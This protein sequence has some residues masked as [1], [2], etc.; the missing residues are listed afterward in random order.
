MKIINLLCLF[1]IS[2]NV[3]GQN[4]LK[5]KIDIFEKEISRLVSNNQ[6]PSVSFAIV[7]DQKLIYSNAIGFADISKKIPATDTT[8]YSIASLTKP[9]ASAIILKLTEQGIIKLDDKMKD[10]WL[11]YESYYSSF[12]QKWSKETPQY[13]PY[14]QN[15][16]YNRNDITIRHHLSHTSE[17]IPGTAYNYNGF[18]YGGLSIIADNVSKKNFITLVQEEIINKLNMDHSCIDF[19]HSKNKSFG[20][21]LSTPYE[22]NNGLLYASSYPQPHTLSAAAGFLSCVKDI[23][24]FD[25]A[26]DKNR[27]ISASSKKEAMKPYVLR[28][29]SISPYGLG[30]FITKVKNKTIVYHYGLQE[31]YSGIY[32]KIPSKNI[33][34]LMLSN[35][36][37]LTKSYHPNLSM[38]I[39]N[40]NPYINAFLK[41]FL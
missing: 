40:T 22:E 34:L 8:L 24:K 26:M 27:I 9:I 36:S 1:I 41:L 12:L 31:S 28:D 5:R 15:Y 3:A 13:L 10:H 39:I 18:L 37:L 11:D 30:W 16:H 29:G 6:L 19:E 14:I 32:I 33:T 35:C 38:G 20:N 2:F 7:N 21:L 25:I 17:N 4:K 23:A